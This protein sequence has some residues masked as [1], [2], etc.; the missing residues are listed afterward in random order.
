MIRNKK[1][2]FAAALIAVLIFTVCGC[3]SYRNLEEY[4]TKGESEKEHIDA[5]A[6]IDAANMT[7]SVAGNLI[8][9]DVVYDSAFDP[10]IREYVS[11]QIEKE[12]E[13]MKPVFSA[14]AKTIEDEISISGVMVKLSY[15]DQSGYVLYEDTISSDSSE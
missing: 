12:L 3:G 1:R 13:S 9:Y 8:R 2:I 10:E 5:I 11:K 14:I 7:M 6:N 4:Y 15:S